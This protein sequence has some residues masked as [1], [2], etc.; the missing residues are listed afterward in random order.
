MSSPF[1]LDLRLEAD[2]LRVGMLSLSEVLLMNDRR[3]PWVIL[4]P[5][6]SGVCEWIDLDDDEGLQLWQ[7][8]MQVCRVLREL[9]GGDKLNIGALG[10]I[11]EQL[12]VHHLVRRKD[13]PAW[14]GPVWG[15]SSAEPYAA[16]EAAQVLK[17]LRD[18]LLI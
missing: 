10:N 11:V 8:S 7:E 13:D 1:V 14:P 16:D 12:H 15:H 2:T 17:R 4:V 18:A 3:Y 5:R 6:R 9:F